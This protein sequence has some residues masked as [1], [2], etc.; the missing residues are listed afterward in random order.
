MELYFRQSAKV[1]KGIS[2][3]NTGGYQGLTTTTLPTSEDK[4]A[5]LTCARDPSRKIT[6]T[7]IKLHHCMLFDRRYVPMVRDLVRSA[8]TPLGLGE[9]YAPVLHVRHICSAVGTEV[10][11]D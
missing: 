8:S 5:R 4:A 11:L 2:R 3:V 10:M 1:H 9:W 6:L 7:K